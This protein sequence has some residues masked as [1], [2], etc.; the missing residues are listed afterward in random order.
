M[1]RCLLQPTGR[2]GAGRLDGWTASTL[3]RLGTINEC[4]FHGSFQYRHDTIYILFSMNKG[5]GTIPVCGKGCTK[6]VSDLPYRFT[7]LPTDGLDALYLAKLA[8]LAAQHLLF[9]YSFLPTYYL[10]PFSLFPSL[11]SR[12]AVTKL[13]PLPLPPRTMVRVLRFYREKGTKLSSFVDSRLM[14]IDGH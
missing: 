9:L 12:T 11:N 1:T 3:S 6:G 13:G 8:A 4:S 7:H 5:D 10:R 2:L 14:D